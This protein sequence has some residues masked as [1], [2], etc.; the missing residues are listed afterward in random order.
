M[1][2]VTATTSVVFGLSFQFPLCPGSPLDSCCEI[3]IGFSQKSFNPLNNS[4]SW[5]GDKIGY[6]KAR[7]YSGYTLVCPTPSQCPDPSGYYIDN[8]AHLPHPLW[9][10]A[11]RVVIVDES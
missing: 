10:G 4:V 5:A 3:T 2:I 7:L 11:L 8:V 1:P 9:S 6:S